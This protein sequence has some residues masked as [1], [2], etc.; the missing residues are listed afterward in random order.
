MILDLS[1]RL[2]FPLELM[3]ENW[4]ENKTRK[5]EFLRTESKRL[6][7]RLP[8]GHLVEPWLHVDRKPPGGEHKFGLL[9]L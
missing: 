7:H 9:N 3:R 6:L 2:A 4:N 8:I 1:H 5:D